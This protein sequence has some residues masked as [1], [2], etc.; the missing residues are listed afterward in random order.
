M[1]GRR[2][3]VLRMPIRWRFSWAVKF[4]LFLILAF[5]VAG[6]SLFGSGKPKKVPL[7][8]TGTGCPNIQILGDLREK[9]VFR[10]GAGR[11][12]F[13]ILYAGQ[14][15][16]YFVGCSI[17]RVKGAVGKLGDVPRTL[18]V[19]LSPVISARRNL[20]KGA[21]ETATLDYFIGVIRSDETPLEKKIIP[22]LVKFPDNH[23]DVPT[24]EKPITLVLKLQPRERVADFS[25]FLGFQLTRDQLEFNRQRLKKSRTQQGL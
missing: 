16:E 4:S 3:L 7:T 25:I 22:L 24:R 23:I 14:I 8:R 17:R 10:P 5:A 2:M 1:P 21:A 18:T 15:T 9:N 6:C 19:R 12:K 11:G 13:D 20:G